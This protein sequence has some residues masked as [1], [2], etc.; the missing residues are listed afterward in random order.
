MT[1]DKRRESKDRVAAHSTTGKR[2]GACF[3]R[4]PAH[5]IIQIAATVDG[6]TFKPVLFAL[7]K[8]GKILRF[9]D[10]EWSEITFSAVR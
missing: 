4:H 5:Q 6:D 10:E 3:G 2:S 9:Q 8:D 1:N 7:T